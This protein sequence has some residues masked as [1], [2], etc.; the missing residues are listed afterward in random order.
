MSDRNSASNDFVN[1][2]WN[3]VAEARGPGKKVR[4]DSDRMTYELR[5]AFEAG[6]DAR[7]ET[8]DVPRQRPAGADTPLYTGAEN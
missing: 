6:W 7:G 3:P 1:N 4:L 2:W 5:H 8:T